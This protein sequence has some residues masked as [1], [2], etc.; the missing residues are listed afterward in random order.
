MEIYQVF[1]AVL[2]WLFLVS[3]ITIISVSGG[4]IGRRFVTVLLLAVAATFVVNASLGFKA[5]QPFVALI[6]A[7]L[8]IC[9]VFAA[10]RYASYWLLWFAGFHM[11]TVAGGIARLVSPGGIPEL[12]VDAAGF[13]AFPA[14]GSA[15]IGVILDR[16][17]G[18]T[19]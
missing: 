15:V 1:T 10:M 6:D 14:L 13:W 2:F 7:A 5:A 19:S 9:V 4:H 3:S 18:I 8:L 17:A 12:Y 16:R 11:I